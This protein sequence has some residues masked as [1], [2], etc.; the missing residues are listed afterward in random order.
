M[1]SAELS[2]VDLKLFFVLYLHIVDIVVMGQALSES[3]IYPSDGFH[4]GYSQVY[5]CKKSLNLRRTVSV[6]QSASLNLSDDS[7]WKYLWPVPVST[8]M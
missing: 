3:D 6:T 5:K 8:D 2:I 4:R 1:N 7:M